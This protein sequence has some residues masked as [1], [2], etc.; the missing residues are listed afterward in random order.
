MPIKT[1]AILSPGDMGHVVGRVLREGG[2]DVVT[3]L[4]GRSERTK[5]LA[6]QAGIRELSELEELVTQADLVL[7]IVVPQEAVGLAREIADA[8]RATGADTLFADCNSTS[9]QTA[10]EIDTIITSAGGRFINASIIGF[11]PVGDEVPRFYTSG[12]HAGAMADLDGMHIRVCPL[13]DTIGRASGLKMCYAALGKGTHA[14][15]IALLAAAEVMGVTAELRDEFLSGNPTAYQR[16]KADI[17]RLPV[18]ARR[19]VNEMENIAAT[20]EHAG[21]TPYF[22]R[23]AADVFRVL[24]NTRFADETPETLDQG[25]TL[26]ETMAEF[27]RCLSGGSAQALS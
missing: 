26:E 18:K 15:Y 16:M 6:R 17:P 11:P 9:P 2:M 24:G 12:P 20:F 4:R 23:G 25:R 8:L 1:V 27:V 14:L 10:E 5:G 19:W 13:G 21:V 7:S 22:H 3:C